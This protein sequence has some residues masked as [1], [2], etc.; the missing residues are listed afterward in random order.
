MSLPY[1]D[2]CVGKWHTAIVCTDGSLPPTFGCRG[3]GKM[4][5]LMPRWWWARVPATQTSGCEDQLE[6]TVANGPPKASCS[7]LNAV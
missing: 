5:A 7:L 6:L 1:L 2:R 4:V 3:E